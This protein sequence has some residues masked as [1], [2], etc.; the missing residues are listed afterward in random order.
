MMGM[1]ATLT[2]YSMY[3][4]DISKV[5][6]L[7]TATML[8]A[9]DYVSE[10]PMVQGFVEIGEIFQG[11]GKMTGPDAV[12]AVMKRVA[13]KGTDVAIGG[14]PV[15]GLWSSGVAYVNRIFSPDRRVA[16]AEAEDYGNMPGYLKGFYDALTRYR[17]RNPFLSDDVPRPL[18][19]LTGQPMEH[20]APE[21]WMR[22]FPLRM[23]KAQYSPAR[24]VLTAYQYAY[25]IP[26][27]IDGVD[28]S[29]QQTNEIISIATSLQ[30]P[31]YGRRTLEDQ[32]LYLVD[33]P[34]FQ[35]ATQDEPEKGQAMIA[36]VFE[37]YYGE[38]REQFKLDS[39]VEVISE[40]KKESKRR[41]LEKSIQ[42]ILQQ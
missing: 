22:A 14:T 40:V 4:A 41:S 10:V 2:E 9:S 19:K 39:N 5:E 6:E 18:D 31:K 7:F 29:S 13:E 32:I 38:A 17:S 16:R 33:S 25:K 27:R 1:F 21:W 30:L 23:T 3:E 15:A 35:M 42:G 11:T 36:Q 34:T 26:K 12:T 37:D 20:P 8:A 24:D 28:L